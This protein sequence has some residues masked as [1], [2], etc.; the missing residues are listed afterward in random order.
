[1]CT[2]VLEITMCYFTWLCSTALNLVLPPAIIM[3]SVIT[4]CDS[5]LSE[6]SRK[7][8]NLTSLTTAC[9]T[10]TDKTE[11]ILSSSYHWLASSF[12]LLSADCG[13][14]TS[15]PESP[16]TLLS[17]AKLSAYTCNPSHLSTPSSILSTSLQVVL[18]ALCGLFINPT[19]H[20]WLTC[21]L[22]WKPQGHKVKWPCKGH[23]PLPFVWRI[24]ISP[25]CC[26]LVGWHRFACVLTHIL[27]LLYFVLHVYSNFPKTSTW[28]CIIQR[29][30]ILH[31]T[32]MSS[33]NV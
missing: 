8:P 9:K 10:T 31:H 2:R 25:H 26:W 16:P 33:L 3:L 28:K 30:I 4:Q 7:S 18:F 29:L 21:G 19:Q 27:F 1:M 23:P 17:H 15:P 22:L 6:T 11:T 24:C 20:R 5:G 13:K 14:P 32:K 12:L